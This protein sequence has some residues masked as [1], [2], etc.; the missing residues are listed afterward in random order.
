M[1]WLIYDSLMIKIL[2]DDFNSITPEN[3][4][5]PALIHPAQDIYYWKDGLLLAEFCKKK[6]FPISWSYLNMAQPGARLDEE[7]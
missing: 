3:C 2:R 1:T 4:M 5:K 6:Q 7:F